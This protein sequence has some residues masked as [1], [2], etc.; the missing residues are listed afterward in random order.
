MRWRW[1]GVDCNDCQIEK[2]KQ[3]RLPGIRPFTNPTKTMMGPNCNQV[4]KGKIRLEG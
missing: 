2:K 4:R 1:G 3:I